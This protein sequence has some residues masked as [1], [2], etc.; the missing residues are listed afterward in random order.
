M[1]NAVGA[2]PWLAAVVSADEAIDD[3]RDDD[4]MVAHNA[5]AR[6]EAADNEEVDS[7]EVDAWRTVEDEHMDGA[8]VLRT[9]RKQPCAAAEPT[10]V[11]V[12][13]ATKATL[14]ANNAAMGLMEVPRGYSSVQQT[15]RTVSSNAEV[16]ARSVKEC[17]NDPRRRPS[18]SLYKLRCVCLSV[19]GNAARSTDWKVRSSMAFPNKRGGKIPEIP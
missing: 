17:T 16:A 8:D 2:L 12:E 7:S 10:A 6:R 1:Q 15:P 5:V 9:M 19:C 3:M 14:A 18:L 4:D 11:E 13:A